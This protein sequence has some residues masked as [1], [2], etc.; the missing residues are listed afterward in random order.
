[1]EFDNPRKVEKKKGRD[2]SMR[3]LKK[4]RLNSQKV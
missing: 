4:W 1:M 3:S 2:D